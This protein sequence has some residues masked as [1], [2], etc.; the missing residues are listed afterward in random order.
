MISMSLKGALHSYSFRIALLYVLFF[1]VS[2]L[3]LFIFI[4]YTGTR[5]ITEQLDETLEVDKTALA[6]RYSQSGLNG[7]IRLVNSRVQS[8]GHDSAYSLISQNQEIIAGNLANWPELQIQD[9]PVEFKTVTAPNGTL[10]SAYRGEVIKLPEDYSLLIA[11]S[12]Q[13]ITRAQH[14]LVN[15]FIWAAIITLILGLIGGYLLSKRAVRRI[16]S[17]NRLCRSIVDGDISQRLSVAPQV[18]DD[19]DDL[20]V[21]INSM[22]DKI[23]GLMGEI[24][25]VSDNIAHDMR[26]PLSNLRLKLEA[27]QGQANTDEDILEQLNDSIASTD[28]II[29]TF[30]ALLRIS[31][32]QAGKKVAQFEALDI[33]ELLNDVIE[34]YAPLAEDKQQ[35][36]LI[37]TSKEITIK[38]D[39]DLL[40]QAV[41]NLLDN[42]VKYTPRDGMISVK[43]QA[44]EDVVNLSICDNGSGVAEDELEQL[45]RRFYR[46]DS[47]RSLPGNG[48]GLS[49]VEA[50]AALHKATLKLTLNKP[51]GL[52]VALVFS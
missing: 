46:V 33:S 34:L 17:I 37:D 20:S 16:S 12:K 31:K 18:Q 52:C 28:A 1:L 5:S 21:N 4:F 41:S 10:T 6:E 47:S 30:N 25:K 14:K 49:L 36:L 45:C 29:D 9:G 15:T 13:R 50:I 8:Q 22:L 32:I 11:R 40:F 3:I 24:V 51:S 39:R 38:G 35:T 23:E 19:L 43:L 48:L 26:T 7:L 27:I 44:N 42:A 2:T